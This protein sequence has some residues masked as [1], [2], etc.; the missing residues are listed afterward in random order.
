M[1][2][3]GWEILGGD[4]LLAEAA[5]PVADDSVLVEDVITLPVQVGGKKRGDITVAKEADAATVEAA[6]LADPQV[7]KFIDGKPIK[8]VI[9]VPGRIVNI[10]I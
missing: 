7:E 4:G 2:E 10:V 3:T 9:V 5:W 8:K 1:A 6:A